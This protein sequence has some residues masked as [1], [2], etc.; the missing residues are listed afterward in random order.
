MSNFKN[1]I[2]TKTKKNK[3]TIYVSLFFFLLTIILTWPVAGHFFSSVASSG[4][5]TMQVIG[6]AGDRANLISEKGLFSGTFEL[7]KRAEFNIVTVYAYFQL[8]FGR[9]AGYNILFFLSFIL[10]GLGAYFLAFYFIKNKPVSLLAGIIFAFSPFHIHNAISTNAGTMHQEWLPFFAL[11]LFKF[12]DDFKLKNFLFAGLFFFLIGFTE[13]QML[14][15]TA[16][17]I[18][19]F[20]VYKLFTQPKVFLNG[21][22][23]LYT[24]GSFAAFGLIFFVMFRSLFSIAGSKNNYLNAGLKSAIKYSND[25]LSIFVPPNFHSFWPEAFSHLRNQFERRLDSS[26]STYAGYTVLFLTFFAII[27]VIRYLYVLKKKAPRENERQK[28]P[29]KGFFFWLAAAI[30]F[31]VLSLGP[32]LHYKGVIDPPVKMP[33]ILLYDYFPFFENIRTTGRLFIYS[34]LAFSILAAWGLLFLDQ[35]FRKIKTVEEKRGEGSQNIAQ[36]CPVKIFLTRPLFAIVGLLVIVDFL[37]IPLKTNNLLHS[38]FY[39]KLGQDKAQYSVLEIPGSTDYDF[40]SRDLVWK[41]IHRKNTVNGYD[42][43]RVN[44]EG[45]TF[46]KSTPII[47]TLLYGIPDGSKGNDR[48][49]VKNSYYD[50]SSE[51]LN[52]YNIRYVILDKEGLKGNPGKG[53]PDMLYPTKAYITNVIKCADE[54]SDD[55]LYACKINQSETPNH[56]FLAMDIS[57]AHWVGKSESKNGLQRWAENGA[58]M[59]LVNMSPEMKKS[60]LNFNL[61]ITKPLR[62]KIFL[63]GEEVYNKYIIAISQKQSVSADLPNVNPGEN[64]ITFGVYGADNSEIHSDK[65]ADTA[66]IYQMEAE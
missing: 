48:D 12:F 41:S 34:T 30:G 25:V 27:S 50:I 11:F 56:M 35:Y 62:I 10:S 8:I 61:K 20:L 42:F 28:I 60:R 17:F 54:Y 44:K 22:L 49:I 31:Y 40:A 29:I 9:V 26:F 32:Y 33:Y 1:I 39:E 45:Y 13:H 51:I 47:R 58:G 18:L 14:A 6:V 65:K 57:N 38:S 63:N 36:I 21:K 23:W 66:R 59:K 64:D 53:D 43:A 4:S 2:I 24:V 37:A 15:F 19:F 5:D 7:I 52:Y 16:I 55:Y 46:Q 3:E